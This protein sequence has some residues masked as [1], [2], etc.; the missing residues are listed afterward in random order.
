MKKV[1]VS[2]A[3]AASALAAAAPASAQYYGDRG[4]QDRYYDQGYGDR[5]RDRGYGYGNGERFTRH[6][7]LGQRLDAIGYQIQRGRAR[8]TLTPGEA[9]R[10]GFE[11]RDLWR[12]AQRYYASGG[13][14]G[15]ERE[16]LM[17]RLDQLQE[18]LQYQQRDGQRGYWRY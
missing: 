18:R 4:Y 7:W 13:L 15:R 12:V 14:D 8:G 6:N 1:I 5:Y 16:I 11:H 10:L 3:L 9:Q 2:L 17:Q